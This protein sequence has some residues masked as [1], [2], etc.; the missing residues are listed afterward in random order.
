[1]YAI[2]RHG[3]ELGYGPVTNNPVTAE[4]GAMLGRTLS[5]WPTER[6][7]KAEQP[8]SCVTTAATA[9]L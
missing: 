5:I 6:A 8:F 7:T 4:G 9:A 2:V 1:L 3:Y